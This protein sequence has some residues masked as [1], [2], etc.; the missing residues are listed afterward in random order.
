MQTSL[1]TNV[2]LRLI[3]WFIPDLEFE[4]LEGENLLRKIR[5][6][7]SVNLFTAGICLVI[8]TLSFLLS[9]SFDPADF[10]S[11]SF[12]LI[13]LLN[14][15]LLKKTGKFNLIGSLSF[16]EIGFFLL[17]L[18]ALLGGIVAS[19]IVFFLLWPLATTFMV[20][21]KIGLIS[22]VIVL[23][24]LGVFYLFYEQFQ[25]WQIVT[26][27]MYLTVYWICF[28]FGVIFITGVAWTYE[29][30]LSEFL[31]KSRTL[32]DELKDAHQ[33]LLEAKEKAEAAN[34][35]KSAFLAIMSHEI[36]TPLNGVIGMTSLVKHTSLN[37]EQEEM[38]E[39][40]RNSGD[41]LLTLINEI[42]DFSKIE[43]GKVELEEQPFDL[44]RSIEDTMEL[45][46]PKAF[47]KGLKLLLD[48]PPEVNRKVVGDITRLRQIFNNLLANAIK[49]TN[50]GEVVISVEVN[51]EGLYYFQVRDSGIGI[52]KDRLDRLFDS[53]SQVDASVTRKYGGTGLGLAISKKLSELMGG[54]MWVESVAGKGST[55]HF[56][57][58]FIPILP[59]KDKKQESLLRAFKGRYVLLISPSAECRK[60]TSAAL[61]HLG[62][63]T[64]VYESLD[65]ALPIIEAKGSSFDFSL[66]NPG[67]PSEELK[68]LLVRVRAQ[69]PHTPIGVKIKPGIVIITEEIRAMIQTVIHE[70]VREDKFLKNLTTLISSKVSKDAL[71]PLQVEEDISQLAELFPFRILMAEDNLVNQKVATRMLSKYGYR[72]DVV[73]NGQEAVDAVRERP[74][75]IL[76]MDIQMPEMDGISATKVIRSEIDTEF[77]PIIIALTANAMAGDR[78][79]YLSA[80]MDDYLSKPIEMRTLKKVISKYG[81]LIFTAK[82]A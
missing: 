5:V 73:A 29:S 53:F 56:T 76:F 24:V 60:M 47:E 36:R 42:L 9:G 15:F 58:R 35:A 2:L 43:A 33:E 7:I 59:K 67:L 64:E 80:G 65:D 37:Q 57:A 61:Q 46:A 52:P 68:E 72:P 31:W 34:Q 30:F 1:G 21:K 49:F 8:P 4:G 81:Q 55:F 78:E 77:Q 74:Y 14:P 40:I 17:G 28:S 20:N 3:E 38:I 69:L 26:G 41:S 48:M 62:M 22:G 19:T 66:L 12:G 16:L 44:R 70:P 45:L 75:D 39:T 79:I 54:S 82:E 23:F 10:I 63:K 27:H 13:V 51:K 6:L 32:M 25:M 11:Y 50:K 71:P 18:C